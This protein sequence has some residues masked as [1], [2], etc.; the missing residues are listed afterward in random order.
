M[1]LL[2]ND[3]RY[4]EA[5][6]RLLAGYPELSDKE[7]SDAARLDLEFLLAG[8][9]LAES[10]RCQTDYPPRSPHPESTTTSRQDAPPDGHVPSVLGRP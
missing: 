6:N 3:P 7:K 8:V 9:A 10:R 4:N 5:F 1:P 2:P